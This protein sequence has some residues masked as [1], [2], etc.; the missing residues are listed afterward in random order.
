MMLLDSDIWIDFLRG[1]KDAEGFIISNM[2]TISF[3]AISEAELL[4]GRS[5]SDPKNAERI[6]HLLAQF[7]K[8]PVDNP[9]VQLAGMIRRAHDIALPDAMIAA[10]AISTD[11]TLVTR[12][13]KD[14]R[15]IEG[16]ELKKPY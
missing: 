6:M 9:M 10:S 13:I 14:Y 11:A 7:E 8:I 2:D 1:S 12:N 5:C 16:L 3:S 4:S 15:S